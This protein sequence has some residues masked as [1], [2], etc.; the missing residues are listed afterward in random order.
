MLLLPYAK[1][2]A[3]YLRAFS[4]AVQRL[5]DEDKDDSKDAIII[6]PHTEE[7]PVSFTANF[8]LS[9]NFFAMSEQFAKDLYTLEHLQLPVIASC[10]TGASGFGLEI[11]LSCRYRSTSTSGRFAFPEVQQGLMPAHGGMQRLLRLA[12]LEKAL[13]WLTTG[14][15]IDA[16]EA[17]S[18]GIV[19][20]I[21]DDSPEEVAIKFTDRVP[22]KQDWEEPDWN[23]QV[24]P[25]SMAIKKILTITPAMVR[26]K[27]AGI[28]PAADII[29]SCLYEGTKLDFVAA[30]ANDQRWLRKLYSHKETTNIL[31]VMVAKEEIDQRAADKIKNLPQRVGIVGAGM[32]G[33]GIAVVSLCA[34]FRVVLY[35]VDAEKINAFHGRLKTHLARS[36]YSQ[37]QCDDIIARVATVNSWEA[38]STCQLVI[39]AVYEDRQLKAKVFKELEAVLPSDAII[40]SN[41]ST[42]P[43]SSLAEY[44][45][46]PAQ[47]VGLHFFSPVERMPLIE[48]IRGTQTASATIDYCE[49]YTASLTKTPIT[50]NDGR[51]FYTSR[52]FMTYLI[53]SMILL[54][55]GQ[56]A[57]RIERA[58][59]LA[60]MPVAPLALADEISLE[61]IQSIFKQTLADGSQISEQA[62][63]VVEQMCE[64]GR[65]GRKVG[66]GFYDYQGKKKQLWSE[67]PAM[68]VAKSA[69]DVEHIAKRLICIQ[70]VEAAR[71]LEEKVV[72]DE[73]DA[74]VGSVLGWGFPA[75]SGGVLGSVHAADIGAQIQAL[76]T[77]YGNR[78]QPPTWL[79][80]FCVDV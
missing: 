41:T 56:D 19:Q 36:S 34:G 57:Q 28:Y 12:G 79:Q 42:L 65:L 71:C 58:G 72:C 1:V 77:A 44:T 70:V 29:C 13:T 69:L 46:R 3:D 80:N 59:K 73:R 49:A 8:C 2:D 17:R 43:I 14:K 50:V 78:F 61:L 62:Q 38:F 25:N 68:F 31:K 39:E 52:V 32:M 30:V 22:A 35:D 6:T 21:A 20:M 54:H 55:E 51:S 5:A 66:K 4:Q 40:A 27:T 48:I 67:L 53:E 60:G 23:W 24:D 7:L 76:A 37:K 11:M 45:Q 64:R 47:F 18:A 9:P 26:K 16:S 33:A 63:Q 75:A 15:S 74:N 10:P